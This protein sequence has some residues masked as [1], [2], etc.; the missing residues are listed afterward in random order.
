MPTTARPA[1]AF[2]DVDETLITFKSMFDFYDF[3]LDA[4]GHSPEEQERLRADAR[5]L[6]RPGMPRQQ[7][8]RLFY[9]RFAGYAEADVAAHGLAWFEHHMAA[10][11]VFNEDVL[12]ALR[13]HTAAGLTTVL[14]SGS[15][16]ACLDPIA[17]YVGADVT[18]CTGL[19]VRDGVYTGEVLRTMI[20]D[21]KAASARELI[22]ERGIPAADCHAYGDHTSDL[23]LL[24]LVGHP[25][26]VGDNPDLVAEAERGG[27]R[28]LAGTLVG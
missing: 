14:V 25:V 6:L 18:L 7:G 27:W 28:R 24:R 5:S 16:S 21:A 9:R 3:F 11:G 13:E 10:G 22:E 19:E 23:D 12:A 8:N 2:F 15:F 1:A 26:V 17:T 20:G 4:V